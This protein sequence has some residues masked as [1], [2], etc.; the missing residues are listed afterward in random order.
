M[1]KKP[2][3]DLVL[4]IILMMLLFASLVQKSTGWVKT[5]PLKGVYPTTP[6]PLLNLKDFR[7]GDYQKQME[8]Q[9][10]ERFG[11]REPVI[12]L[13]NQ[14][15]W[16]FYRKT[17]A[18]DIVAGKHNWLYYEQNVNDYYGTEMYRW[19][20]DALTA[21]ETFDREARLMLKL[22]GVLQDYGIE[23]LMFIAPEK[24]FLYPEH[25]PDR[26]HDTNSIN[27]REYYAAKFEEN[28]FPYIE[29][30]S[31][32][33]ALKEADTLPYSLISQTGAHW[34]FSSV[35]AADSLLRL[36]ETLKGEHLPKLALGPF[37]ESADSTQSDDHD[38]EMNLNLMRKMRHPYDRLYDADVTVVTN[39]T[40]RKPKVLFIGNS[41]LWRMRYYIPFEELF[42]W[43][44]FWF[45]NSTAYSGPGYADQTP[46]ADLD[47]IE[48]VLD[49]DYVVWF[50]TG[51][52]M[53]KA[54]YGFVE[55]ALLNFCINDDKVNKT[56]ESLMDS[57]SLSWQEANQ[58]LIN[59]PEHYF[60]E[61]AV[62][63]IPSARNPRVRETLV[64]NEIKKDSIWMW[65]LST[66]QT[67][68]QNASLDRVL[69][70]EAHNIIDDKPLMR[71]MSDVEAKRDR[72]ESLVS[73]MIEEILPQ[74]ELMER[75][76]NMA[77]DKGISVEEQTELAA[78]WIVNDKI[79]RGIIVL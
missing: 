28:G 67:V 13:Y 72:V 44:E 66:C 50:T 15:L 9:L 51:N 30:T 35:L 77:A 45:Y 57:L 43:S 61:L 31:W 5:E 18:H 10:S 58:I 68:I 74:P 19:L 25:L 75:I 7:S 46:V 27:A 59:D 49:A 78:R 33:Q 41:Y 34:G 1:G 54:T 22:R 79:K 37:H 14:Y 3:Y 4:F 36:M 17:Y 26:Q 76:R 11:F 56:R 2:K 8:Q 73:D 48:K 23:F 47:I 38:L 53:Y 55:R 39:S 12:R 32:F 64:I 16:D 20:P 40:I 62:D 65:N 63:S 52:Q 69:L 70:M 29:M 21:R 6:Y 71:D 24:G 42:E 60:T